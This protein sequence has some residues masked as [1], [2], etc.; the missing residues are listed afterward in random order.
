MLLHVAQTG[1]G[2]FENVWAWTADHDLDAGVSQ[3]QVSYSLIDLLKQLYANVST[4]VG[5]YTYQVMKR[6]GFIYV[7]KLIIFIIISLHLHQL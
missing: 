1:S 7:M 6:I 3:G 4:N 2:Y 5:T